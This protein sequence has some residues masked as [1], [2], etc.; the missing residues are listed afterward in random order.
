[1]KNSEKLEKL[2]NFAK[3][4]LTIIVEG[5][6]DENVLRE[7]GFKKIVKIAGKTLDEVAD[8]IE[9]EVAIL[10]D[11]D[12]KG[13]K[14]REELKKVLAKKVKLNSFLPKLVRS[15]GITKIEELKFYTK[16]IRKFGRKLIVDDTLL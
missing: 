8:K 12:K 14:M 2:L 9:G 1:M 10:T 13:N 11:F 4:N 7:F 3:L 15:L 6:K 5:K 16:F